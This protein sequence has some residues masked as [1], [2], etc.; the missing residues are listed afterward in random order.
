MISERPH[1]SKG[2][3]QKAVAPMNDTVG[4]RPSRTGSDG[5]SSRDGLEP[6][7]LVDAALLSLRIRKDQRLASKAQKIK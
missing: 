5:A 2:A 1:G 6:A 3:N 7:P 4:V